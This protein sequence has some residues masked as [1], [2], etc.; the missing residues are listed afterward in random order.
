GF[1]ACEETARRYG[2]DAYL[3]KEEAAVL[4]KDRPHC[5]LR[6]RRRRRWQP[7]AHQ[8]PTGDFLQFQAKR[9]REGHPQ[10]VN[11][12]RLRRLRGTVAAPLGPGCS[13]GAIV[14]KGD[15]ATSGDAAAA[16]PDEGLKRFL[17]ARVRVKQADCGQLHLDWGPSTT[18]SP[19]ASPPPATAPPRTARRST[20]S[21]WSSCPPRGAPRHAL[22]GCFSLEL[23]R[24][25]EPLDNPK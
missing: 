16:P 4:A 14:I 3:S 19:S 5:W 8:G 10:A 2:R 22:L 24:T 21:W 13:E 20:P 23:P 12:R 6:S 25:A 9:S 7:A 1:V 18:R 17:G 11:A 15:G